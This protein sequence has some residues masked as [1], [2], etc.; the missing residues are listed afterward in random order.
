M[1]NCYFCTY[2]YLKIYFNSL[3]KIG[4]RYKF[5][6]D[7][8]LENMA[9]AKATNTDHQTE[10]LIYAADIMAESLQMLILNL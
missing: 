5:N 3:S 6:E 7:T 4:A 9:V 10:L 2:F 1:Q 8:A